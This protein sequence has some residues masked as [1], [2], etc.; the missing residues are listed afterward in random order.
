[1]GG[2]V[3]GVTV[4]CVLDHPHEVIQTEAQ[5]ARLI[6]LWHAIGVHL[7]DDALVD[8]LVLD[9][10]SCIVALSFCCFCYA[11]VRTTV[12]RVAQAWI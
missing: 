1:M 4:C 5:E 12:M 9:S 2:L 3:G 8:G 10:E 7:I 11:G 6:A